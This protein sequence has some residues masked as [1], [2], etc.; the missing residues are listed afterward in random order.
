MAPAVS[1]ILSDI[2]SLAGQD[3]FQ[4][5]TVE[6]LVRLTALPLATVRIMPRIF[7]TLA[8]RAPGLRVECRQ[9]STSTL[10]EIERGQVDFAIGT[11]AQCAH[12]N[13]VVEPFLTERYACA[14][15]R[16]HPATAKR[17]TRAVFEAW[18]HLMIDSALPQTGPINAT[19][20]SLG[21]TRSVT[22]STQ[23]QIG[24]AHV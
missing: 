17:F 12:T 3:D 2:A 13:L 23:H 7:E 8:D 9:W 4:P 20:E 14:M 24:R 15:R 18:P 21:V 22:Y 5:E 19:L 1:R 16:D 11:R 10:Q 6:S